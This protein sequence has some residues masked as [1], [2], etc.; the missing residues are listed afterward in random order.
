M[1]KTG[2]D[3]LQTDLILSFGPTAQ[4]KYVG[5]SICSGLV[6]WRQGQVTPT[7][8]PRLVSASAIPAREADSFLAD[9]LE[10]EG[11]KVPVGTSHV[12]FD[13]VRNR[14]VT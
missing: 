6:V 10:T 8:R 1:L 4:V 7:S 14:G 5:S 9:L 12:L 13:R 3:D 2:E 11:V